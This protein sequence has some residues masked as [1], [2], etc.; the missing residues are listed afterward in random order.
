MGTW[1]LPQTKPQAER[2]IS[3]MQ[4]P[5]PANK[6]PDVLYDL[7]GSDALFDV[8]ERTRKQL[9]DEADMRTPLKYFLASA[10]ATQDL[11]FKPWNREATELLVDECE[12]FI[13]L[14]NYLNDF[15]YQTA[16]RNWHFKDALQVR[17]D[18]SVQEAMNVIY[19]ACAGHRSLY[20]WHF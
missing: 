20:K 19:E 8:I 10:L 2:L 18:L 12:E 5:I 15:V 16:S 4:K 1:S 14:I 3:L 17:P 9:G 6:A 13:P 11:A 7:F